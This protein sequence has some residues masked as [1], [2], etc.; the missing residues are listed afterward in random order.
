MACRPKSTG[1]AMFELNR[2]LSTHWWKAAPGVSFSMAAVRSS[3]GG[4]IVLFQRFCRFLYVRGGQDFKVPAI[5]R[6]K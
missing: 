1:E 6:R 3:N 2:P 5:S 4:T